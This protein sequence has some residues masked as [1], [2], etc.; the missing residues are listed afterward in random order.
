MTR[1]AAFIALITLLGAAD[2]QV[3]RAE[4]ERS[5]RSQSNS[6]ALAT[7]TAQKAPFAAQPHRSSKEQRC[8]NFDNEL[9]ALARR[10]A[11]AKSTGERDQFDL[12]YRRLQESRGRAGC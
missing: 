9:R 10:S 11:E 1:I 8:R 12:Q 6:G 5:Q 4:P 3:F 2:A 7:P